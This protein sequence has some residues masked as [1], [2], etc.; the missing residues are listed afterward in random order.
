[1]SEEYHNQILE[2]FPEEYNGY[3]VDVGM[4]DPIKGSNSYLLEVS[5][6]KGICIEPNIKY[7]D[8]AQGVRQNIVNCACGDKDIDNQDFTIV[9]I[10]FG[11]EGAV[12][13]L[14]VDERL[15]KSHSHLINH[16]KETKVNVRKLDTILSE[17]DFMKQIDFITIDTE[18]TELDVLKGFDI[19]RWNPKLMII[20]N[21][22]NEPFI[23][24]YLTNF[25]YIKIKRYHVNDF[26]IR[27]KMI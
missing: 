12:S 27:S 25:G 3:F 5:G 14:K 24:Q 16:I 6:W 26:Y 19:A 1:M 17:F 20:E 2:Y 22:Y 10:S 13:S 7:C 11:E 9:N 23:E 4:S 21:N 18:N 15:L 8:M